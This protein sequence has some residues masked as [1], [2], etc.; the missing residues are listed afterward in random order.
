MIISREAKKSD[1]S[2]LDGTVTP[3]QA[4]Q[5]IVGLT[6]SVL[7]TPGRLIVRASDDFLVVKAVNY[8]PSGRTSRYDLLEVVALRDCLILLGPRFCNTAS[9]YA[10][11]NDHFYDPWTH[12]VTSD[13]TAK[14]ISAVVSPHL[15]EMGMQ[16]TKAEGGMLIRKDVE[17]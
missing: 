5:I 1:T 8:G 17:P 7:S 15:S 10:P 14:R 2:T 12:H 13:E 9:D 3:K 4:R 16:V 11:A 6:H